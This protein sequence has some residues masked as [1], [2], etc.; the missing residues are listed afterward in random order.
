MHAVQCNKKYVVCNTIKISNTCGL[1]LD[2]F[3]VQLDIKQI[4]T[5]INVVTL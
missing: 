5:H 1:D 3:H 2:V 4:N